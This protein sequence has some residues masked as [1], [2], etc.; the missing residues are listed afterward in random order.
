MADGA[1][2]H[3]GLS[4]M[5]PRE[6]AGAARLEARRFSREWG[7]QKEERKLAALIASVTG[8]RPCS[9]H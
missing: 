2:I 5:L 9:I 6:A 8:Q 1:A 7:W 3:E 4:T